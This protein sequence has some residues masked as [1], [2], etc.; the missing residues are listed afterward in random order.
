M[1]FSPVTGPPTL[2]TSIVRVASS[3]HP[4]EEGTGT[5]HAFEAAAVLPFPVQRVF[6]VTGMSAGAERGGHANRVVNEAICCTCGAIRIRT[7]NGTTEQFHELRSA[8]DVLIV[9]SMTWIDI[10]AL[11]P[12]T[13]YYV[14]ADHTYQDAREHYIRDFALFVAETATAPHVP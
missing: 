6:T 2:V 7:H 8:G 14:L 4:G 5:L 1:A 11:V 12:N 10:T 3:A 9:P 13:A